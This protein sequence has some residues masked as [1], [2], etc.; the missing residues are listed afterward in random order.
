[1]ADELRLKA[2]QMSSG[3]SAE[4]HTSDDHDDPDPNIRIS[5]D[6]LDLDIRLDCY[7][8]VTVSFKKGTLL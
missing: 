8:H 1:V 6:L 4:A 7:Y 2:L 3:H 5:D